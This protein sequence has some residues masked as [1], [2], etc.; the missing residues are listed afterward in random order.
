M[1]TPFY[2][3]RLRGMSP[4]SR[5]HWPPLSFLGFSGANTVMVLP[6]I[7]TRGLFHSFL[8][9]TT[10]IRYFWSCGSQPFYDT[11]LEGGL[12]NAFSLFSSRTGDHFHGGGHKN[13][14]AHCILQRYCF[15]H[16]AFLPGVLSFF[17]ARQRDTGSEGRVCCCKAAPGKKGRRSAAAA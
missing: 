7:L 1:S 6:P 4:V 17:P 3:H 13:S 11:S 14:V 12:A 2:S 8:L 9:V 15:F 10:A 16:F 5:F